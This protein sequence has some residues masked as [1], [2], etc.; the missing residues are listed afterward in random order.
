MEIIASKE[1]WRTC[2]P[3]SSK[4]GFQQFRLGVISVRGP[5]R[6]QV[7]SFYHDLSGLTLPIGHLKRRPGLWL[8]PSTPQSNFE[9][10]TIGLAFDPD[11]IPAPHAR[12]TSK[13]SLTIRAFGIAA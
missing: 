12:L 10:L 5:Q 4:L 13:R 6:A 2:L 11:E 7:I 3:S 9:L 8:G 1:E